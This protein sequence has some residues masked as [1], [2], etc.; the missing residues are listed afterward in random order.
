MPTYVYRCENCE[1][2]LER[3]QSLEA[4]PLRR[5]PKCHKTK[6]VRVIQKQTVSFR[7]LGWGGQK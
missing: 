2:R 6:L 1:H 3:V 5:C 7:G 4:K